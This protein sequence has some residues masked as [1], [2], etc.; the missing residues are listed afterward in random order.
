MHP[1]VSL[2]PSDS[3][4]TLSGPAPFCTKSAQ[5]VPWALGAAQHVGSWLKP[6]T[7][8]AIV[9]HGVAKRHKQDS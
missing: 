4:P 1:A 3:L 9:A 5:C 6:S 8:G 7:S 2:A